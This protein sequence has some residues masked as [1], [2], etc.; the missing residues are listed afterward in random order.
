MSQD[1]PMKTD[2]LYALLTEILCKQM[3]KCD[4]SDYRAP[5]PRVTE[6]TILNCI[7]YGEVYTHVILTK[8]GI[9]RQG[10]FIMI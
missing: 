3:S 6:H 5:M 8:S 7:Q 1:K 9:L 2:L 4:E 10:L